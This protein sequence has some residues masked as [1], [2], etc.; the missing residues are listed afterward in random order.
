MVIKRYIAFVFGAFLLSACQPQFEQ[1][2][3]YQELNRKSS[4]SPQVIEFFGY[5]CPHCNNLEPHINKWKRTKSSKI[6][7]IQVPVDF[8]NPGSRAATRAFYVAKE[9]GVLDQLHQ[10]FFD[11]YHKQGVGITG[12]EQLYL[13]L[14]RLGVE[15]ERFNQVWDSAE[16]D[17]QIKQGL[18]LAKEYQI[19]S[20]PTFIINGK[21]RTTETMAG[22]H[23]NLTKLLTR[24]AREPLDQ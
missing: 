8:G 11:L 7:F 24:L 9:L 10:V 6:E 19:D 21:F 17:Q 23:Q 18:Q 12:K 2:E 15:Q 1:K 20:V 3:G 22:G 14:G 16:V 4:A 5:F 13:L